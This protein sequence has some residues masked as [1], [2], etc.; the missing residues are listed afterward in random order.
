MGL[1]TI[2]V[3]IHSSTVATMRLTKIP[4]ATGV[5]PVAPVKCGKFF[6]VIRKKT[7]AAALNRLLRR[8]APRA[9]AY[10]A[11]LGAGIPVSRTATARPIRFRR[12]PGSRM[13]AAA[14]SVIHPPRHGS[15]RR[16][17]LITTHRPILF[18]NPRRP[19]EW[20]KPTLIANDS[21][22]NPR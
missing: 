1:H 17:W 13:D 21:V 22:S 7:L 16:A 19:R 11:R 6:D 4:R 18:P 2:R 9:L 8:A 15:P 10:L 3:R 20:N 12:G 14:A 5:A